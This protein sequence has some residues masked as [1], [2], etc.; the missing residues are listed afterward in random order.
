[1][2]GTVSSIT[3]PT[4]NY[5]RLVLGGEGLDGFAPPEG[6]DSYVNVAI[7]PEG[8]EYTAP[9]D[10][11]SLKDL[12]REQRPYRRRYT[13]RAWDPEARELTLEIVVHG[14]SGAGSRW[15]NGARVGDALVFTGPAG[16]YRPDPDA[17]WYLLV[18]DESALPAIAASLEAISTDKKVVVRLVC[19]GAEHQLPLVS[20]GDLDLA[21]VHRDYR[22]SNDEILAAA[23]RD[24]DF[25]TG[26][27]DAFVHGEAAETRAVRMHLIADRGVGAEQLSC[28]PYWRRGYD[29]EAWRQVK[30][31]WNAEVAADVPL[32]HKAS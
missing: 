17:D 3:W 31:A 29:D 32:S 23:V 1:M 19:D 25:P 10:L 5:A 7:P 28:S 14:D 13:V 18:G 8:A 24:L 11:D 12:P 6:T 27:V 30:A 15:V 2:H 9:F 4:P 21:W 16:N 26:H 22:A 20:P